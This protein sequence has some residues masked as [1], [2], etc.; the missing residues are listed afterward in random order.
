MR[1]VMLRVM[2]HGMRYMLLCD[3][4]A[5]PLGESNSSRHAPP[6]HILLH[7]HACTTPS[8]RSKCCASAA[9][10]QRAGAAR[11]SERS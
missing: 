2:H 9:S 8:G 7:A 1:H 3:G 10:V 5:Q 6:L 4:A 11:C